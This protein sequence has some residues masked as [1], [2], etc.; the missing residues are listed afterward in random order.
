MRDRPARGKAAHERM[1]RA[2]RGVEDAEAFVGQRMAPDAVHVK[3]R[4]MGAQ[5]RPDGRARVRVRPI[6]DLGERLPVGLVAQVGRAR[7]GTGDDQAVEAAVPQFFDRRIAQ[8]DTLARGAGTGNHGQG[9]HR[10][11]G[12]ALAR[13]GV[14]QPDELPFGLFQRCVRHIVDEADLDRLDRACAQP[15]RRGGRAPL[16]PPRNAATGGAFVEGY[17]HDKFPRVWVYSAATMV[18]CSALASAW[19]RSPMMSSMCSM[20]ML[21]RI[22]SGFTPA[23]SCSS[24]DICRWVVEAGWQASDLASPML[25]SRLTSLSPS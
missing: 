1:A 14:E 9:K 5:A 24:G 12:A 7:L 22:I 6:D 10:E 21:S 20:P 4:H 23:L 17:G 18:R 3:H 19:S 16:R 15:R 11:A 13:S 25:T 8:L 2:S